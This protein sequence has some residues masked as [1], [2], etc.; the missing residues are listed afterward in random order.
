M[1][2]RVDRPTRL[3]LFLTFVVAAASIALAVVVFSGEGTGG[4]AGADL[5]AVDESQD[6]AAEDAS[7]TTAA[8]GSAD[9]AAATS[10]DPVT[11]AVGEACRQ[12]RSG[13]TVAD[14]AVWFEANWGAAELEE[15]FREVIENALTDA[16]PEVVPS[17]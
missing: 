11:A 4:E 7:P 16:C 9:V 2:R 5:G 3:I 15:A 10:G 17:D 12:F 14:F 13:A 6:T 8:S 1:M